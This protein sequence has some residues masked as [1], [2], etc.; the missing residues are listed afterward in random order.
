MLKIL[1]QPYVMVRGLLNGFCVCIF[2]FSFVHKIVHLLMY[3]YTPMYHTQE[4]KTFHL[5]KPLLS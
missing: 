3:A 4:P 5:E 1:T 2:S